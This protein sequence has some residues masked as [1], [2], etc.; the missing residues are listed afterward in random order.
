MVS[1]VN[2]IQYMQGCI[3]RQQLKKLVQS[4]VKVSFYK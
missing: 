1:Y 3:V 2:L 4:I